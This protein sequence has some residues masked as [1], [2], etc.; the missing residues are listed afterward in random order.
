MNYI[1]TYSTSTLK[2]LAPL[3]LWAMVGT[4][5]TM[6]DVIIGFETSS[7]YGTNTTIVG[8]DD[9]TITGTA[10]WSNTFNTT[11]LNG[12]LQTSTANPQSGSQ[13][14]R[15]TN[16]ATGALGASLQLGSAVDVTQPFNIH[17]G[18]AL[19]GISANTGNQAQIYFGANSSQVGTLPY[20]FGLIYS[21]GKLALA[22]N[23]SNNSTAAFYIEFGNYTE[24]AN[25]GD[26]ITFDF[27][28][29]PSTSKFTNVLVSGEL[30]TSNLTSSV[31]ASASGGTIPHLTSTPDTYIVF[32]SGGNDTITADFDNLQISTIPE[33]SMIALV[34]FGFLG[35]YCLRKRQS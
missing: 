32:A 2:L 1:K 17:F 35:I 29:N 12:N 20:W 7:G 9:S 6:G 10:A 24:Y 8:V 30:K 16:T 28:I 15:L 31:Q 34:S 27:T 5:S 3:V 13:A 22:L 23:S 33:P 14:L 21:D 4:V 26:Y 11:A 25:L 18:M 19:S